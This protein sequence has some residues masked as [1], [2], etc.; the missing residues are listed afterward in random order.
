MQERYDDGRDISSDAKT[1]HELLGK[2]YTLDYYQREYRWQTNQVT[3]LIDDL[4]NKF[5]NNY[6]VG[7]QR[8]QVE[9][10]DHY[11]LGSIIVSKARGKLFIVDGQQRLTTLT[12]LLIRLRQLL[13]DGNMGNRVATLIFSERFGQRSFNL[14]IEERK[15]VMNALYSEDP[16]ESFESSDQPESI[17]NIVARY[18]DIDNHFELQNEEVPYFVDWLLERVYLVQIT[19]Y[20]EGDAYTIFETMND[21]GLSLTPAEMLRGY[22]LANIRDTNQR[23]NANRVWRERIQ[24]LQNLDKDEDANAIKAWLRSQYAESIRERTRGAE[25]R[26]F[27]LI[28]TEFHRWVRTH[29]ERLGLHSS[30]DFVHF[31]EN[32]FVF[33]ARY[34][35]KLMEAASEFTPGLECVYYNAQNGFA[36][37][38][39]VLLASLCL[40]D[41]EEENLRKI[42]VV[43][44]YLDILIHR[45]IWNFRAITHSTM[46]YAMF[47]VMRDI[48]GK[49]ITDLTDILHRQ[50]TEDGE[51]FLSDNWFRLHGTNRKKVHRILARIT[52]YMETESGN[53]S[54]Y[55]EYCKRESSPYEIEHIWADHPEQHQDDFNHEYDFQEYRNFIG[56]LLLLPK[57][58]NTS[59]G[60]DPYT[61]KRDVYAGQN[62]LAKSLHES[63]YEHNP[64][65]RRFRERNELPFKAHAEFNRVD[66]DKRQRLYQLLAERIW[67][68]ERLLEDASKS[69]NGNGV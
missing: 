57:S 40:K 53:V 28:G 68:P 24:L 16:L 2:K 51:T 61:E 46:F 11:F 31:I 13:E 47:L 12:L 4:T 10:Y 34:Y 14:D 36:L 25:P 8:D 54:R 62:L 59:I 33:Y 50:L 66:L 19:A 44:R 9:N 65:F 58:V 43:S 6:Q 18:N 15:S 38:Y 55:L 20:D 64:G 37:Q 41:P 7:D 63:A 26:D 67:S 45:R 29:N 60:D 48:R 56:G 69:E 3:D 42:Q 35:H 30:S 1:I 5:F 17:R 23:N 32:N 49:S 22:L 21:R 39:P 52:D 27:E